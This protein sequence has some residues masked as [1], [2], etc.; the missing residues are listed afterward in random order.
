[1]FGKS[2]EIAELQASLAS[3]TA[4]RDQL[5]AR[6]AEFQTTIETV[7]AERD[8]ALA[9]VAEANAARLTA[10]VAADARIAEI[11]AA[12]QTRIETEVINRLA[13]AGTDPIHRDP[14]ASENGS[15]MTHAEFNKLNHAKRN[16]F[17]R[18]GGKL[19]D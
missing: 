15:T 3:V 4:E 12:T 1:M 2:N 7:T 8:A 14:E 13:S 11:E 6:A 17:I 10:Q 18:A 19:T 5:S 9:G 16:E